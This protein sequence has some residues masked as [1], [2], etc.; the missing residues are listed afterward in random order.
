MPCIVFDRVSTDKQ[1]A[2]GFSLEYQ[3]EMA[4]LYTKH[5]DLYIVHV[6]EVAESGRIPEERKIFK[7]M[8]ALALKYDIKD[9]VFRCTDR[10][11]RNSQDL[12]TIEQLIDKNNFRIHFYETRRIIDRKSGPDEK[13]MLSIETAVSKHHSDKISHYVRTTNEKKIRMGIA[14]IPDPPYGYRYDKELKRHVKVEDQRDIVDWI[15]SSYD[16]G[17]VSIQE[18]ADELIAK[19]VPA[20]RGKWSKSSVHRMLSH[21]FYTGYFTC[22]GE[23]YQGT[24]EP[25]ITRERYDD[26]IEKMGIKNV[27]KT[28]P[29][30]FPFAGFVTS[31]GRMLTGQVKKGKYIY[32]A[33]RYIGVNIKQE[34]IAEKLDG[35][36]DKITFNDDTAEKL[37]NLFKEAVEVKKDDSAEVLKNINNEIMRLERE[38]EILLDEIIAGTDPVTVRKRTTKNRETIERLQARKNK[39]NIRK[40]DFVVEVSKTIQICQRFPGRYKLMSYKERGDLLKEIASSYNYDKNEIMFRKPFAYILQIVL[41][42]PDLHARQDSNLWP[43]A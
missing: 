15:F 41:T 9:I 19:K 26:R 27:S 23:E 13:F 2:G 33:S 34:D 30:F 10:M 28:N 25:Y 42:C 35:I 37:E 40:E 11:N 22:K 8:I 4:E 1:S 24:H 31:Q 5:S 12:Y 39:L 18:I 14:P 20:K 43:T 7:E 36:V 29:D 17:E 32:Y 16:S 3:R 6:F 21:L 38:N